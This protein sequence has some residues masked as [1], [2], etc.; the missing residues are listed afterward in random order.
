MMFS[1]LRESF[2]AYTGAVGQVDD[3]QLALWFNEAQLDLAYDLAYDLHCTP[4][5]DFSG[6][7]G[8]QISELP[9]PVHYLL[10]MFAA[11]Q[12]WDMKNDGRLAANWM[13]RY[14]QD[15]SIICNWLKQ[16]VKDGD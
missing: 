9:K 16:E 1:E 4:P 10:A 15:K 12:Y 13:Y 8:N 3:A 14:Y 5:S 11:S 6:T 7:N 2:I